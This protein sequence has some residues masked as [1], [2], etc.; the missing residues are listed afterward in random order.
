METKRNGRFIGIRLLIV[1][2]LLFFDL[3]FAHAITE[4][5]VELSVSASP[6]FIDSIFE[7]KIK[8]DEYYS[9]SELPKLIILDEEECLEFLDSGVSSLYGGILI[10][11]KY[12]LKKIGS[13]LLIPYLSLGNYQT[14]LKSFSIKAEPPILSADTMFKWK[15]L[16]AGT[17]LPP[18]AVVQ[19]KKY[20]IVL[21]GFFYDDFQ[22]TGVQ[23]VLDINCQAPEDSILERASNIKPDNS[24]IAESGWR[25]V[26]YFFWTPLKAGEKK[27]PRP[28]ISLASESK[29]PRKIYME[30][31]GVSVGYGNF[32]KKEK[33]EEEKKALESLKAALD[34][35][36][37]S[38][39]QTKDL[40]TSK[41]DFEKKKET[42]LKIAQ[43]RSK[44][45]FTLFSKETKIKRAEYEKELRLKDSFPVRSSIL[46]K[47][48]LILFFILLAGILYFIIFY[49][50]EKIALIIFLI[51]SFIVLSVF[52]FFYWR[53]PERAMYL[54]L[55]YDSQR[56]VYHIPEKS[57]TIVSTLE[58]G[59]T[60][61]I[62]QKT[63]E[64]FFIE[65]R[66]GTGGWQKKCEFIITD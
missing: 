61:I 24:F 23:S 6:L 22:G 7:V 4:D 15:I 44:E 21:M 37:K 3:S 52:I 30:E 34:T 13:F 11:N 55:E 12:K 48:F 10:T 5:D 66:D 14:K 43:L 36:N 57:G 56:A 9:T 35:G 28:Q 16:D 19:G 17:Y 31:Q 51:I 33:T 2:I 27:L 46:Q 8:L 26:S 58:V 47:I 41:K 54:P 50:K 38:V 63:Y 64:W 49:K 1:F 32:E 45:A 20:L 42:A 29:I 53:Q 60:V 25:S 65:K 59:E 39:F 62:R 18:K 40:S